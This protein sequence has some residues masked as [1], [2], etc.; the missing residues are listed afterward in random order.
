MGGLERR[1]CPFL[2]ITLAVQ[3]DGARWVELGGSRTIREFLS[4]E[5]AA[6]GR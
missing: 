5:F 2:K 6:V 4:R 3:P 1:C